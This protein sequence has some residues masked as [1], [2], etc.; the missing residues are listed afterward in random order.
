MK[1]TTT[2]DMSE[3]WRMKS[4]VQ[5]YLSGVDHRSGETIQFGW[6]V[7]RILEAGAP[8][9]VESLDF[10]EM[11][12]FTTDFS[13]ANAVRDLQ[14]AA[15]CRSQ[16]CEEPC[17]LMQT[18]LVS[19]SYAPGRTDAFLERQTRSENYDAGWYVGVINEHL[20]LEEPDS[21]EFRSLYEISIR[22]S[23][24][25]P[26]WLLPVGTT[27]ILETGEVQIKVPN[28]AEHAER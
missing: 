17:N 5:R 8:P 7:F 10:K 3:E 19:R 25:T 26:F 12:S 4:L 1:V 2:A 27:V 14:Y 11:A 23:R 15:L 9:E 28:Q 13:A 20:D 22:D 21:F 16:V 18:A 24:T 6:F